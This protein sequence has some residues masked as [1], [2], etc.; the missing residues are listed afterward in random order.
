MTF[1][2]LLAGWGALACVVIG[3]AIYR[4]MV[5]AHE[6]DIL[7][8]RQSEANLVNQQVMVARR[9]D[10]IDAWGKRLTIVMAVMG[11]ALASYYLYV[12]WVASNQLQR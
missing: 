10:G 11:V 6:D 5:A 1:T 7:H 9:L 3:L 2:M 4:K 12:Q 8:L